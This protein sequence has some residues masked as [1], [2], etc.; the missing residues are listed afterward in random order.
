MRPSGHG[1]RASGYP[2]QNVGLSRFMLPLIGTLTSDTT[3]KLII[4]S[5]DYMALYPRR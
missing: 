5:T 4:I 2:A 1:R 3:L